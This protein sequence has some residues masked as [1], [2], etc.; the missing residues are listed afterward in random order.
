MVN[1]LTTQVTHLK[2]PAPAAGAKPVMRAV[3]QKPLVAG[4][5]VCPFCAA[6][7]PRE[8]VKPCPRC[9]LKDGPATRQSTAARLGPW[10]VYQDRNPAAPGM[11]LRT[12]A[13]LIVAKKVGPEAV[14]R[15]PTTRQMWTR[16]KQTRGVSRLLGVC[17]RCGEEVGPR[18]E[19]CESCNSR[20]SPPADESVLVD[21]SLAN[22]TP[23]KATL[24]AAWTTAMQQ[25]LTAPRR[26][27]SPARLLAAAALLGIVATAGFVIARP[28]T[29]GAAWQTSQAWAI[30]ALEVTRE[31][32]G[33]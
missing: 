24:P 4:Q 29:A 21:P 3:R 30:D 11:D 6:A 18:A 27:P 1:A 7:R 33:I 26:R 13:E 16:A 28:T 15:G 2:P 14:I 22:A 8:G 32:L 19:R 23:I 12:L 31:R 20:Q 17:W 25:P 5:A 10:Y 9:G